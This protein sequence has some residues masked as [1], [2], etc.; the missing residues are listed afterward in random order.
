[1]LIITCVT[2][3]NGL[4]VRIAEREQE[5]AVRMAL[6]AARSRLMRQLLVEGALISII[7]ATVGTLVAVVLQPVLRT[8]LPTSVP[9]IGDISVNWYTVAFG[10]AMAVVATMLAAI[11]PAWGGTRVEAAAMLTRAA[12]SASAGRSAVRWRHGLVAAQAAIAT[13]LLIFAS[14]LLTSFWQLG[15]VPLGFDGDE[16]VTVDLL[17]LDGKYQPNWAIVQFQEK[18]LGRLRAIPEIADVGLTSA[19]PFRN[20]GAPAGIR[21]SG[22]AKGEVAWQRFVDPGYF[23]VLRVAPIRGRLFNE[24]DREGSP[25]VVVVSESFAHDV[26]GAENPIGQMIGSRPAMEVV[27]VVRDLR[28]MG[29]D[30]DPTPAIYLPRAQ[31]PRP[32][33]SIVARTRTRISAASVVPTIRRAIREVDPALPVMNFTTVDQLADAT[34]ASR[35]FYTV[36]TVAFATIALLL[37]V[38]G[39]AVVV[40]R[41]VAERRRELAIRAALGATIVKL[42]RVAARDALVAVGVGVV[43]GM[44]GAYAGSIFLTQF[45]FHI[46]PHSAGTYAAVGLLLMT[47]ASLAAWMPMRRFQRTSVATLLKSE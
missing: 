20:A 32:H 35:R 30:K 2:V 21:R 15:R 28:Y 29:G 9:L 25:P 3:S 14:L 7:G 27:G 42:G 12:S 44:A 6:G 34:V 38:V 36:A 45:L 37:T 43:S 31:E 39:L 19:V 24:T 23:R 13:A 16:V 4:L 33:L 22:V 47:V 26:F 1:M 5:L 40:A 18:L 41:V 10:A 11:T 17:L 8:L 46:T